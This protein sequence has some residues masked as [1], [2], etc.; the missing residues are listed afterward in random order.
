MQAVCGVC[1]FSLGYARFRVAAAAV[2]GDTSGGGRG[3]RKRKAPAK[4]A[5]KRAGTMQ[6]TATVSVRE[7]V[8]GDPSQV[9]EQDSKLGPALPWLDV[10]WHLTKTLSEGS[11]R[12]GRPQVA[13]LQ[14]CFSQINSRNRFDEKFVLAGRESISEAREEGS[15]KERW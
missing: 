5:M 14:S 9:H 10:W 2:Y 3:A 4:P 8:R 15:S 6:N 12:G 13:N 1:F 11:G 7:R